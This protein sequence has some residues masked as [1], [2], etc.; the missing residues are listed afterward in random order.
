MECCLDSIKAAS[1]G[2]L[3]CLTNFFKNGKWNN[4]PLI[5]AVWNVSNVLNI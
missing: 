3:K 1:N 2:H 4:M 5:M